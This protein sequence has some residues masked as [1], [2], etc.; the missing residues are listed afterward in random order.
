[1]YPYMLPQ[2]FGN[3][4]PLY[5]IFILIGVFSMLF[6]VS[7]RFEKRDNIS[8]KITNKLLLFISISLIFALG[9]SY[10]IDG[11]F[12]SIQAGEP[13]FESI[14]FLG[15]LIGGIGCFIVLLKLFL[16]EESI[17][18][19]SIFGTV[20]TGVVLA[21]AFGRI[22]CFL[23]GCCYGVPT[24]SLLGVTFPY[25]DAHE[26]YEGL[27]V[28]PTQLFESLFLFSLFIVL[29]R[30]KWIRGYEIE[31]YLFGYGIWRIL[32]EFIRGDDRGSFL[33]LV[34]TTYNTYPTPSQFMS[35]LM[36]ILGVFI[37]Y[38]HKQKRKRETVY[39]ETQ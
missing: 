38:S 22:G 30:A 12:H 20:L 8:V 10:I 9:S 16:K 28:Y 32:I 19:R 25:G 17:Q 18:Y 29:D 4:I 2:V 35:L 26:T 6:Y 11:L 7:K 1:M 21:H 37:L 14:S 13:D 36:V 5:D 23:A 33:S 27:A 3:A 31:G 15:G 24:D 34:S 39:E